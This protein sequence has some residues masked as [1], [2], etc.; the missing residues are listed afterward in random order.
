ME[1]LLNTCDAPLSFLSDHWEGRGGFPILSTVVTSDTMDIAIPD[2]LDLSPSYT[3]DLSK[4]VWKE[5]NQNNRFF[6][7]RFWLPPF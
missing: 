7:F 6:E 2:P 5:D 3:P 4:Q 1:F